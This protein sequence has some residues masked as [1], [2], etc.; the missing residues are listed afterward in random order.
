MLLDALQVY[1][2]SEMIRLVL[3]VDNWTSKLHESISR[4]ITF[5]EKSRG[6]FTY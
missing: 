3:A 5:R 1:K 2:A 6:A 4:S